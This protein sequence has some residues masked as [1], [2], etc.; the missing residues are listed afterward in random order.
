MY[1]GVGEGVADH[2]RRTE[3]DV[4]MHAK[5]GIWIGVGM[6]ALAAVP[7][8]LS[9]RNCHVIVFWPTQVVINLERG[10]ARA[11]I[12]TDP[13]LP[14]Y[15]GEVRLI[16]V[17]FMVTPFI[18]TA[19]PWMSFPR[20]ESDVRSL[21]LQSP[22]WPLPLLLALILSLW[23]RGHGR[24]VPGARP[25]PTCGY[26][27]RGTPDRPCPECGNN[28]RPAGRERPGRWFD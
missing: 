20:W 12:L 5:Q 7:F 19:R 4:A 15:H 13:D 21:V 25:C 1:C 10:V 3:A 27:L 28:Q 8:F 2:T 17:D 14:F 11:R 6:V 26:D 22:I 24:K 23:R 18:Q 9:L 16:Q